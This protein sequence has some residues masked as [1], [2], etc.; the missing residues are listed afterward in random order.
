MDCYGWV[1]QV[2]D[3]SILTGIG[4]VVTWLGAFFAVGRIYG[5]LTKDVER[6]DV[7]IKLI[8]RHLVNPDGEPLLMS[9][10]AHDVSQAKCQKLMDERYTRM[11]ARLD[12]HDG[13]LDKILE[14]V[15]A[16]QERSSNA[17]TRKD[18]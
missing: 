8:Q 13:K 2:E 4:F 1:M 14:A 16:L 5:K 10:K 9:Y 7:D 18:D 3:K 11:G 15:S 12:S 17:R 6:H